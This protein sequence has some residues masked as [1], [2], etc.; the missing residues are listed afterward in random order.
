MKGHGWYQL[1]PFRFDE[2]NSRLSFAVEL[3][4]RAIDVVVSETPKYLKI[5]HSDDESENLPEIK[6]CFEHILRLNEPFDEFHR[7]V[8]GSEYFWIEKESHGALLRSPTVFEDLVKTI[9]TTN[10]SWAL[11]KIMTTNLVSLLG[12]ET[13]SGSRA[14]PTP[15]S[16][17]EMDEAFFKDGI[18]AGYRG[19]YL[20]ELA[21][22]VVD[23]KI[24]PESWM[25]ADSP[26]AE[27]KK[28]IKCIK[29]VGDYAAEHILKMVGRYD[30]LALDSFLRSEFYKNHNKGKVC[31][32]K[33]I[34]K[35]YARFGEW[36]GLVI[37]FDAVKNEG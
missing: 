34:E 23:G 14:F 4:G 25:S 8:A 3:S 31:A 1:A 10:C 19:P 20:L 13:A 12:A 35:H 33:K 37:W 5:E 21:R 24:N 32:D 26:T 6:K 11:T 18:R 27:L 9:C 36:R 2:K 17:A 30:G 16:M 15:Q 28:E 7:S 29:G 22:S